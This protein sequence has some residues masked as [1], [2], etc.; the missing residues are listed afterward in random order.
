MKREFEYEIIDW[1]RSIVISVII[2]IGVQLVVI[3]TMVS[4]ESMY[5]TLNDNDF[6]IIYKLAYKKDIPSRGDIIVFESDLIDPI[7]NKYKDLVK[8]VIALP[9]ESVKIK[10]NK[11]YINDKLLS[12]DYCLGIETHGDI[13]IVVPDRQIFVL[14]DNRCNSSDSRDIII[15]TI[16]L[17]DIIGK[18]MF[19][20]FPFNKI[21]SLYK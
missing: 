6:L 21:G 8:R 13:D 10:D 7:T 1:I 4:G 11:V 12:E 15:G 17:D 9:G 18:A 5:P 19:R 3:P 20:M 16:A 2:A 14:G